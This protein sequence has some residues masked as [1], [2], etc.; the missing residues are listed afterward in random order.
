L[1]RQLDVLQIGE[2]QARTLG[3]RV[4]LVRGLT[5]VCA[6]L[7]AASAVSV[8]GLIGF[9]GLVV[10]HIVRLVGFRSHALLIP[11]AAMGGAAL[12]LWADLLARTVISPEEAPVGVLTAML[13]GPYF[14]FLLRR[15]RLLR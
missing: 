15:T 4:E 9:L 8:T 3:M 5:L 14:L 1:A 7:L 2:E 10:P 6:T 12:L 13:G 11:I